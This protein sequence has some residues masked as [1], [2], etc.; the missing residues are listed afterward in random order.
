MTGKP[1]ARP[2]SVP[3]RDVNDSEAYTWFFRAEYPAVVRTV[4]LVVRDRATAEDAAQDGFVQLLRHWRK[5]SRYERPE[6]WVRRVAIRIAIRQA[7]RDRKR[8]DLLRSDVSIQ[9]APADDAF[10]EAIRELPA[11]QRA[12]L[13]LFYYEDRPVSEVA[14]ILGCSDS[15]VKVHLHRGRKRLAELVGEEAPDA[16]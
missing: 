5:V 4:Y 9:E 11:Q 1:F 12:A 14:D 6:A 10:V 7:K 15:T 8:D 13:V 3:L 2:G 16:N